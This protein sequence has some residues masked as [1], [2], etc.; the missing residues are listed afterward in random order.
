MGSGYHLLVTS[1][2]LYLLSRHPALKLD[3]TARR[4][5]SNILMLRPLITSSTPGTQ[6]DYLSA[7]E[8]CKCNCFFFSSTVMYFFPILINR[9]WWIT[10]NPSVWA[11][12]T[13][14]VQNSLWFLI[15][16]WHVVHAKY[17]YQTPLPD[18]CYS[19]PALKASEA[20]HLESPHWK[21][22]DFFTAFSLLTLQYNTCS[23][24]S[25][26]KLLFLVFSGR[27][28]LPCAASLTH[29]YMGKF[30]I[31]PSFAQV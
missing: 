29:G 3:R 9:K 31:Y 6:R 10:G 16:T 30:G 26:E 23:S 25:R 8:R 22:L 19:Q 11:R 2:F 13:P 15:E 4:H 21:R 5:F 20:L 18:T 14:D 1:A 7:T 27:I 12:H 24:S 17:I 28:C